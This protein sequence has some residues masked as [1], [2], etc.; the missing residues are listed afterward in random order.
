M[1]RKNYE[2]FCEKLIRVQKIVMEMDNGLRHEVQ[3]DRDDVE[4]VREVA[5]E[6]E[7]E[8][9]AG[10]TVAVISDRQPLVSPAVPQKDGADDV[11]GVLGQDEPALAV[12][13]K[14]LECFRKF[15][16]LTD[17]RFCVPTL[18]WVCPDGADYA[19][20]PLG[21]QGRRMQLHG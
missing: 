8:G 12:F 5:L 18:R 15:A 7:A 6:G 20:R 1:H 9:E 16:A 4:Q 21:W 19:Q 3:P 17:R 13:R 14:S 10:R 11:D 2:T